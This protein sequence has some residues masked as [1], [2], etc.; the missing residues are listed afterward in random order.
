MYSTEPAVKK[1]MKLFVSKPLLDRKA[2]AEKTTSHFV[3][4]S[5]GSQVQC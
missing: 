2:E 3:Y 5:A 4:A 1:N